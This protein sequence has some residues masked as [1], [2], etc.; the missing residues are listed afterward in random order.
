MFESTFSFLKKRLTDNHTNKPHRYTHRKQRE[1]AQY[2]R[3]FHDT[4][5]PASIRELECLA[6]QIEKDAKILTT[7]DPVENSAV[8]K[9]VEKAVLIKKKIDFESHILELLPTIDEAEMKR[10]FDRSRMGRRKRSLSRNQDIPSEESIKKAKN[11]LKKVRKLVA[12]NNELLYGEMACSGERTY[13]DK[14]A[15]YK[16]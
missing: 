7:E 15:V 3:G 12:Q 5:L 11:S 1:L 16:P 8:Q 9:L 6:E 14:L 4:V 13:I 10:A 2:H